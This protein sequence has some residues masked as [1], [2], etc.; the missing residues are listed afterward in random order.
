M[1][2]LLK[3][4]IF[5]KLSFSFFYRTIHVNVSRFLVIVITVLVVLKMMVKKNHNQMAVV[6]T[7]WIMLKIRSSW[8]WIWFY[9]SSKEKVSFFFSFYLCF[10]QLIWYGSTYQVRKKFLSS[11]IFICV[12]FNSFDMVQHIK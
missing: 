9:I 7:N 11:S 10:V 4:T 12:S 1:T 6:Q 3:R 2:Y 8:D 5:L